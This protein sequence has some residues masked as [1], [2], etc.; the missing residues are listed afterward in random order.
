MKTVK[1]FGPQDLRVVEVPDPVPASGEVLIAVRACGIC[2]SD[3]WFWR[4]SEPVDYVAGHEV[5]GEVVGLGSDVYYLQV[6][7]RVT[8]NNVRGCGKCPA[9]RTGQFNR[10]LGEIEHM[11][12]GFAELIAVPE[13][14]CLLLNEKI[15][16]EAGSL[17]FD[18]WGTPYGAVERAAVSSGDDV[19]VF[20]CGPIGLSTVAL[21]RQ[22]GAY[23]MAVDP[24]AYRR[25]AAMRLG[26]HA[27]LP[28]DDTTVPKVRELTS[29]L[30]AG[31]AIECSGK[32]EAYHLA[33]SALRIGGTLVS[34]G[35][36]A[37][38]EFKPSEKVIVRSLSLLGSFY[39]TLEQG[40]Q[41][42]NL[43]LQ[44]QIDPLCIVTHRFTLDELPR[45]F[46]KVVDCADG[47]LKAIMVVS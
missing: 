6:G 22:R 25:E 17:V 30:G 8:V 26:A 19:I 37:L 16:Y 35:E 27:A 2:G 46:G 38:L 39:S 41:V 33:F 10:C 15:G 31:I 5:A 9:C 24:L 23:V 44:E 45:E 36:G 14:N 20:G 21:A 34:I 18:M 32:G 43:M 7:D 3:K 40:R 13:R 11:G 4:V 1:A 42:Q 47:I 28:P 29:D 12:H